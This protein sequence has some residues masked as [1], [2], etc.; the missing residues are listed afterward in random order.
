MVAEACG[1]EGDHV[2]RLLEIARAGDKSAFDSLIALVYREL[3]RIAGSLLHGQA[4]GRTLQ[5]TALVNEAW[6]RLAAGGSR[7]ENKAHFF[8]A[9]ARAMRQVLT[10][11]ARRRFSQ[12]R[13]GGAKRI[14]LHDLAVETEEPLLDM[15]ALDEA[16]A[17]L[18]E[19]NE[20]FVR[21]IEL[22]YFAGC[23]L[24]EVAELTGRSLATVKRDWTYARAW[25][26]ERMHN[27]AQ[28]D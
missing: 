21:L 9:A 7:W 11:E 27:S 6:L 13:G 1:M 19:V 22:R 15:L 10:E 18:A 5:P 16:M 8:G 20:R 28:E 24:E 12:K 2:S 26:F 14:T 3:R 4:N 23:S 17:A 25:L